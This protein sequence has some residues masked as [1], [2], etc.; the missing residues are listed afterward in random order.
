ML[1]KKRTKPNNLK[2]IYKLFTKE[3]A[4]GEEYHQYYGYKTEDEDFIDCIL[5][6]KEPLCTAEDAAKTM[7]MVEFLLEN[8]V[9]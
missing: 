8:K 6:G 2:N 4:G 1:G 5:N 9:N 3:I 7:D